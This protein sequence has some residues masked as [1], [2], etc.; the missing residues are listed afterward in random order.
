MNYRTDFTVELNLPQKALDFAEAMARRI[1][2]MHQEL[3]VPD[4]D[5]TALICRNLSDSGEENDKDINFLSATLNRRNKK[6]LIIRSD[7]G[8]GQVSMVCKFIQAVLEEFKLD[9]VVGFSWASFCDKPHP[10]GCSGGGVVI[11]RRESI[12]INTGSWLHNTMEKV[13]SKQAAAVA[14]Q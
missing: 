6:T 8:E 2:E 3:P 7:E 12:W 9:D 10:E 4:D 11:T 1:D 14:K 13:S 5:L